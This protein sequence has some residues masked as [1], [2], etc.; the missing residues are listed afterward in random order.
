MRSK[1]KRVYYAAYGSNLN[2]KRF[3]CYI[4]GGTP[5]GALGYDQGCQQ[6]IPL[7]QDRGA[8]GIPYALYFSESSKR[9]QGAV[10]FLRTKPNKRAKTLGRKY[11]LT[12]SQFVDVFKQENGI[13]VNEDL[14][15][16]LEKKSSFY[17]NNHWYGRIIYLGQDR[18]ISIFTFTGPRKNVLKIPSNNYLKHIIKGL[19]QVYE[20]SD[21]E[22]LKYL[23]HKSGIRGNISSENMR[24]LIK[25]ITEEENNV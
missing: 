10:A 12:E 6:N 18:G 2:H 24:D 22:I 15:L 3:L 1:I 19:R 8:I 20:M 21:L 11:L 9:W 4:R 14:T 17:V 5:E 16:N 7:P 13:D 25:S 23:I